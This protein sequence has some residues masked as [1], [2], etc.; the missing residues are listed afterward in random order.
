MSSLSAFSVIAK[1]S[2]L[3]LTL[4]Q[5]RTTPISFHFVLVEHVFGYDLKYRSV[6]LLLLKP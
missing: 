2:L 5:Q 1:F 3:L 4:F 6:L